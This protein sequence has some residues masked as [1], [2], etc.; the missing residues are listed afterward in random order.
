[1]RA[2]FLNP[3]FQIKLVT[4]LVKDAKFLRQCSSLLDTDDFEPRAD[5]E[6][7]AAWH[8]AGAALDYWRKYHEPIGTLL[9]TELIRLK[10]ENNWGKRLLGDLNEYV[11]IIRRTSPKAS[12]YAL[13]IIRDW[14]K[15][16]LRTTC[17]DEIINLHTSGG[18][19]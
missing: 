3:Q 7:R 8:I 16:Q 19:F 1:M 13:E 12:D 18:L 14:R 4:L 2:T 11:R 17:I 15:H 10:K 9:N 6:S 5:G